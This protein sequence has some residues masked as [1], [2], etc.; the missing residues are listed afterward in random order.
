MLPPLMIDL[1]MNLGNRTAVYDIGTE[2][3]RTA[4][5]RSVRYWRAVLN[6][7]IEF[8]HGNMRSII[9]KLL[10]RAAFKDLS[11]DVSSYWPRRTKV[12]FIDPI[13]SLKTDLSPEDIVLCHDIAPVTNPEYYDPT[14]GEVYDR[15]YKRIQVSG[16]GIVFVSDFTR[17]AYLERYPG[18]YRFTR[19]IP[20]YHRSS[21]SVTLPSSGR[22][23]PFV[24]MVGGL[25]RRKNFRAA[26]AAFEASELA[27]NDYELVIAGPRGNLS[28]DLLPVIA[29]T[30]NVS[31]L[32]YVDDSALA[33]L[34]ADASVLLFP[35][36]VEGFGVPALE[37]PSAN[38]LPIV[39]K[40]T[41]LEEI[42]GPSGLLVDPHSVDDIAKVLREAIAMEPSER[43]ARLTN[44]RDHQRQF[45]IENFRK[46][47]KT[48]LDD[49][50]DFAQKR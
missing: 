22:E 49:E 25:E 46:S 9:G 26:I 28:A 32:G 35:S 8:R 18:R 23:K 43:E 10:F 45:S 44:I 41:V 24:L 36:L 39:S 7:P 33:G 30:E 4:T 6:S 31:H 38:L 42:V 34:Y 47:W 40:G 19:V 2:I 13:F 27:A 50:L 48:L 14:A 16:P 12:L 15:A 37:A 1:T 3:S 5:N 29:A 11:S 17:R 20:L 21:L